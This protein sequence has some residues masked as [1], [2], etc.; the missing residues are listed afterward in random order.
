[1]ILSP[2]SVSVEKSIMHNKEEQSQVTVI[3][4]MYEINKY[5]KQLAMTAIEL[6]IGT[7]FPA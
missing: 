3:L 5:A 1:M 7:L 4:K 6:V 2:A